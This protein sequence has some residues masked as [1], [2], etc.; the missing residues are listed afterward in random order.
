[1]QTNPRTETISCDA[2]F[3][4]LVFSEFLF[5]IFVLFSVAYSSSPRASLFVVAHPNLGN[6]LNKGTERVLQKTTEKQHL[7]ATLSID[8]EL[9][10]SAIVHTQRR[11]RE[12]ETAPSALRT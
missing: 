2:H 5:Y 10:S 6:W 7:A 12:H 9:N 4:T 11:S 1:M 8:P 3:Q